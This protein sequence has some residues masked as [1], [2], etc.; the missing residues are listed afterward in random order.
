LS[1]APSLRAAVRRCVQPPL[2]LSP[3]VL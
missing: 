1:P 3:T 2:A